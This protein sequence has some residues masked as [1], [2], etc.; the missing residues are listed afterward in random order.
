MSMEANMHK[1]WLSVVCGLGLTGL[2]R[3]E[4]VFSAA[5]LDLGRVRAGQLF[6][7]RIA[8][9]NQGAAALE[10]TEVKAGC[11]CVKAGV[12]PG[13]VPAGQKAHLVLH[14]NTLSATPGPHAWRVQVRYRQGS[15]AYETAMIVK[16]EVFQEIIV[17]PPTIIIYTDASTQHELLVKDL[18]ASPLRILKLEPSSPHLR[19]AIIEE[20]RTR[21]GH[22]VRKLELQV[23]DGFAPGRHDELLTIHTDDPLH[24][25]LQVEVSVVKRSRQRFNV[26]PASVSAVA[27]ASQPAPSRLVSIRDSQGQPVTIERAVSEDPAI[28]CTWSSGPHSAA[29]VKITVERKKMLGD[30]LESKVV[31]HLHG[32]EQV[33]IPVK[34]DAR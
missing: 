23:G 19:T 1:A 16:A 9:V 34:C 11:S 8:L 13:T 5:T 21:E 30:Y 7:H 3:G 32:G 4:L 26:L 33:T 29:T 2:A 31:V 25:Q 20:G 10:I 22:L 17:Q 18:R 27:S 12:E 15:I 24:R 14:I 6:E 28:I